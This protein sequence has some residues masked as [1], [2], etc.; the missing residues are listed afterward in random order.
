MANHQNRRSLTP[1]SEGAWFRDSHPLAPRRRA[2]PW[3]FDDTRSGPFLLPGAGGSNTSGCCLGTESPH[4][5]F[6]TSSMIF[7]RRLP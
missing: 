4:R 5:Y 7:Q 2:G 3:V 6:R 1:L